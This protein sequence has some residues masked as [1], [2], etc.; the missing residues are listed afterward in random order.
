MAVPRGWTPPTWAP[1]RPRHLTWWRSHPQTQTRPGASAGGSTPAGRQTDMYRRVRQCQESLIMCM[2]LLFCLDFMLNQ[3]CIHYPST[4]VLY[5]LFTWWTVTTRGRPHLLLVVNVL[6]EA[7]SWDFDTA[8]AAD[9]AARSLWTKR[10]L[11]IC[12]IPWA[13]WAQM[14]TWVERE[15][16]RKGIGI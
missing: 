6:A 13:T 10:W 11:D 3:G 7:E 16:Q 12:S 2:M 1:Q 8:W 5:F 4:N 15:R 9:Q 14:D